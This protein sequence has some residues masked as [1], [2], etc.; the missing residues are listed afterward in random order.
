MAEYKGGSIRIRP[1][2]I[3]VTSNYLP[4]QCFTNREDIAPILRRFR[5]VEDLADLPPIPVE[6]PE[7]M[8]EPWEH[9]EI[10]GVVQEADEVLQEVQEA[11]EVLQE[12]QEAGDVIQEVQGPG[13]VIQE[14]QEAIQEVQEAIQERQ[15][16]GE[17]QLE[18]PL[19]K[20]LAIEENEQQVGGE[21]EVEV[22]QDYRCNQQ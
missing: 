22:Q 12:V 17:G 2:K 19:K 16:A 9:Q 14:V 20:S 3:I 8:L 11:G 18:P 13:E 1:E 7:G 15:E 4:E 21:E 5:V 6:V 10:A